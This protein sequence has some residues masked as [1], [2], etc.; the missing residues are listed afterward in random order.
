[1]SA[2]PDR[3]VAAGWATVDLDRAAV[4]LAHLLAPGARFEPSPSSILLGATCL[5]G[6]TDGA[7]APAPVVVL[8]EPITEGRLAA[9][10]AR[11]GEGW[12]A[13]W[14]A[15]ADDGPP[16]ADRAPIRPG[17]L[18]PERLDIDTPREGPFRLSVVAATIEP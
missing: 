16:T 17:P 7:P 14:T 3:I 2:T 6:R 5:V 9:A 11:H 15:P 8:L 4:E 13:T 10:L 12:R 18:G 1:M